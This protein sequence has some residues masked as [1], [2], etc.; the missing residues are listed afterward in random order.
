MAEQK[1]TYLR[2]TRTI[3][4]EGPAQWV[5]DVHDR[6]WCPAPF[7][8]GLLSDGGFPDSRGRKRVLCT[9]AKIE[10]SDSP[11]VTERP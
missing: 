11:L 2:V 10:E 5:R 3:V 9:E 1:Q 4:I 8:G 6:C 7:V